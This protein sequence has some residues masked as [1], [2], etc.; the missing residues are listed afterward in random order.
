M[1]SRRES[2]RRGE[3]ME[4]DEQRLKNIYQAGVRSER[5]VSREDC[6]SPETILKLLRSRLSGKRATRAIDHISRCGHCAGEFQ[7]L[8]ETI[9]QEKLL[10]EQAEPSLAPG[11]PSQRKASSPQES[12]AFFGR[13]RLATRRLS[14]SP[15]PLLAGLG[16]T[17][18]AVAA[19]LVFRSPE[20]Y[21]SGGGNG[22]RLL[23]PVD[24]EVSGSPLVF[25]WKAVA[26]SEY[27]TLELYDEALDSIWKADEIRAKEIVLPEETVRKLAPKSVFFWTVTAHF[28]DGEKRPSRLEKFTFKK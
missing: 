3:L 5:P 27:Y 18:L 23:Q 7:F 12:K 14:W 2:V 20:T 22:V 16:V 8:L 21:R 9:R 19:F 6:P 10:I 28:P 4:M 1:T 26:G 25:R 17:A 11:R 13:W 15:V 24:Q